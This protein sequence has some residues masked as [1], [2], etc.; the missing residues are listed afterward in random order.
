MSVSLKWFLWLLILIA[1]FSFAKDKTDFPVFEETEKTISQEKKETWWEK[2]NK[3]PDLYYPHNV[4]MDVMEKE[5]DSCLLCHPFTANKIT[6]LEQL[7]KLTVIANEPLEA[8]CHECHVVKLTA[9]WRCE[10]CHSSPD[11]IWPNDHNFN[12]L[13]HHGEDARQ[14]EGKCR[15]CHIDISFCSDCHFRRDPIQ[16]RVHTLGYRTAHGIDAR[17]NT[18]S[19]SRCHNAHYCSDCHRERR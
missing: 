19:C 8:I 4:H 6:D 5:G 13:T 3:R 7:K 1:P 11:T 16:R 12:Y 17:M 2:R 15:Q 10:L 14:D 18:A 9:P